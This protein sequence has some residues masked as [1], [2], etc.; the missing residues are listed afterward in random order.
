MLKKFLALFICAVSVAHAD[1]TVQVTVINSGTDVLE[2]EVDANGGTKMNSITRVYPAIPSFPIRIDPASQYLVVHT[3]GSEQERIACPIKT[4]S[5]VI[6]CVDATSTQ[7]CKT[8][9]GMAVN[10]TCY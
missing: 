5:P 1:N 2:A 9:D 10:W 8:Q 3:A 4:G 6:A 7:Q